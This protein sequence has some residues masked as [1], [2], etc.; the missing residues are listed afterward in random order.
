[1]TTLADQHASHPDVFLICW[2][3]FAVL[4][5][6]LLASKWFGRAQQRRHPERQHRAPVLVARVFGI[7]ALLAGLTAI[8]RATLG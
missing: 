4:L 5:G 3:V 7:I 8:A 1:M 6:T 2:G